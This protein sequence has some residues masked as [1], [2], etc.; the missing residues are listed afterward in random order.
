MLILLPCTSARWATLIL[1]ISDSAEIALISLHMGLQAFTGRSYDPRLLTSIDE[2]AILDSRN[3]PI[4]YRS[5]GEP[6]FQAGSN[7]LHGTLSTVSSTS[8]EQLLAAAEQ[9]QSPDPGAAVHLDP[10]NIA[11]PQ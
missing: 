2:I 6:L 8:M 1:E 7:A 5:P 11:S 10:P 3:D 4:E 9:L